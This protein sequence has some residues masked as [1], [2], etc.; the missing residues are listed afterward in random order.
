[1]W[2]GIRTWMRSAGMYPCLRREEKILVDALDTL[3]T[4]GT[5]SL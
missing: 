2:P 4:T 1:M 5:H 3:R